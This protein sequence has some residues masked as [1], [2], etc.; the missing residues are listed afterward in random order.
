MKTEVA[1]AKILLDLGAVTLRPDEPFRYSSGILSPI[2]TDNRV[3]ISHPVE[4]K[5]IS[6]ALETLARANYQPIDAVAGTATAGISWAAWMA[7]HMNVPMSY[8]RSKAKGHGQRNQVEGVITPG[9]RTIVLEDLVSTGA[10]ALASVAALR[11]AGAQPLAVVAIF[12]YNMESAAAAFQEAGVPL[13]TLTNFR[14][15]TD[16]AVRTGVLSDESQQKVLEW[17]ADPAGWGQK[18]GFA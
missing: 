12:T 6:Q 15:L 2:Y 5:K 9:A 7:A 17:A 11:E 3:L 4:R 1:I 13:H 18:M 16:T 8:V 14:T 10:S